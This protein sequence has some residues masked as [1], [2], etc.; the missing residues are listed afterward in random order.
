M[1][2]SRD[3]WR[4]YLDSYGNW[5]VAGKGRDYNAQNARLQEERR[6]LGGVVGKEIDR[7][8]FPQVGPDGK[9]ANPESSRAAMGVV[10]ESLRS[11]MI[12]AING[13]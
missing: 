11:G 10:K 6:I 8:V 3:F 1:R 12:R 5:D 4:F 13:N 7:V 9:F 2:S